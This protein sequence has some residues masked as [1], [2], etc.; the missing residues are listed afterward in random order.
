MVPICDIL[1]YNPLPKI[2]ELLPKSFLIAR[3]VCEQCTVFCC[4]NP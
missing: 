3:I 2:C 1:R 4:Q